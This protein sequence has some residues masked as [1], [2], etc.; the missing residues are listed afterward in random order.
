[1][2]FKLDFFASGKSVQYI[3]F[4]DIDLANKCGTAVFS[5]SAIKFALL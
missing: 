5:L 3:Y 2:S 1:M 4:T